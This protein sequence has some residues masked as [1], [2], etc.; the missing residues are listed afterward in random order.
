MKTIYKEHVEEVEGNDEN[1]NI[2][3]GNAEEKSTK[4]EDNDEEWGTKE[5]RGKG[6]EG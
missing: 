2:E 1:C 4:K 5:G 6:R 3:E